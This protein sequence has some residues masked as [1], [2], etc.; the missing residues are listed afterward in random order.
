MFDQSTA[1]DSSEGACS[2][3]SS[4]TSSSSIQQEQ[5]QQLPPLSRQ[6][7]SAPT[8]AAAVDKPGSAYSGPDS[9]VTR[10]L[11]FIANSRI[12]L[13]LDM[14]RAGAISWL[15]SPTAPAAWRDKN[16]INVWDQG[17]L[18]QQSFYGECCKF[19]RQTASA[20][21][22]HRH[23]LRTLTVA[24]NVLYCCDSCT[25]LQAAGAALGQPMHTLQ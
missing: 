9:Q 25:S 24:I 8:A 18:L 15:S 4:S 13:G 22:L 21:L 5:Q 10:K 14:D 19:A 6:A 1:C 11:T 3:N 2:V 17:R 16:V 12:K 23:K 7:T 20:R